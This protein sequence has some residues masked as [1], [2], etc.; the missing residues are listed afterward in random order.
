MFR[1]LEHLSHK[2]R[3]AEL[4]LFSK[5]NRKLWADLRAVFQ[6]L[7]EPTG[8]LKMDLLQKHIVTGEGRITSD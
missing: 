7:K 6:Y 3:P 8:K 1:G 2:E 4:E 5:K